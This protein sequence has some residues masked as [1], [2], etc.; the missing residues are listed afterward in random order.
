MKRL[1]VHTRDA[2]LLRR[3]ALLFRHTHTVAAG[4]GEGSAGGDVVIVDRDS[5]PDFRGGDILLSRS[6]SVGEIG[7]PFSLDELERA[8]NECG[9]SDTGALKVISGKRAVRLHG[10][11][12]KLTEVEFKLLCALLRAPLGEFVSRERLIDEIWGGEC[13][14]GV[15]NVYIHY[16]RKKLE[17]D[18]EKVIISSRREGYKIDERIG[19]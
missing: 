12:I 6:P 14:G 10:R 7:I 17:V 9:K 3:V 1:T 2:L 19:R 18:G 13:D 16:L 4:N 15:V 8:V 5:Y 11:V